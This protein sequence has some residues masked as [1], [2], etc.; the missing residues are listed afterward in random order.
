MNDYSAVGIVGTSADIISSLPT[1]GR[2]SI[3]LRQGV[4]YRVQKIR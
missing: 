2:Y 1:H 3:V 4:L